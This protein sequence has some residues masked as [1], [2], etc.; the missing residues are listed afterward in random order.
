MVA[1]CKR[2][3]VLAYLESLRKA[4]L[5]VEA[6]EISPV[7]I[8]RLITAIEAQGEP[9][10]TMVINFGSE[11]S[12]LTMISGRRLLLD[13]E[14]NFGEKV[15]IDKI[16]SALDLSEDLAAELA[17]RQGLTSTGPEGESNP[18]VEIVRP[19]FAQLVDEISRVCRYAASQTQ[20]GVID[21][22]YAFGSIARWPGAAQFLS[23]AANIPVADR[24]SLEALFDGPVGRLDSKNADSIGPELAVATGLALRGLRSSD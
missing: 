11:R 5:R 8:N 17:L 1:A 6:L 9:S 20:G 16:A 13:Q 22:V 23:H 14:V 15:L 21:Q 10:N 7:A 3:D 4:G 12:Y 19:L 2:D 24:L 18:V